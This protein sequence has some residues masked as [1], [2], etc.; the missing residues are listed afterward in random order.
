[1]SA[2]YNRAT[3]NYGGEIIDSNTVQGELTTALA[4]DKLAINATYRPGDTVAFAV[5]VANSGPADADGLRLSDDLGAYAYGGR[6]LV[7]LEYVPG[8]ARYFINGE[9]LGA[10]EAEPG[11]ALAFGGLRVPANGNATLIYAARANEFAPVGPEGAIIST[12][13]LDVGLANPAPAAMQPAS[14]AGLPLFAAAEVRPEQGA[15]LSIGKR[16]SPETVAPGEPLT[17]TL[18]IEN[19]GNAPVAAGDGATVVDVFD[20]PLEIMSVRYNGEAWTAPV[21]YSYDPATGRFATVAGQ[22]SVP[23]ATATQDGESGRW[24]VEPGASVIEITGTLR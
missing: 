3:L 10:P 4:L 15:R 2:F 11:D 18:T 9:L 19:D 12:S 23:A 14:G 21:N 16:L 20:P 1:M 7:P 13:R 8:S 5:S 24:Q 6:A 22:L 17:Y